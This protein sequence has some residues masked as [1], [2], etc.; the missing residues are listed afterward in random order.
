M[1]NLNWRA[2][3][4]VLL[5]LFGSIALLQALK[6][7]TLKGDLW[8]W[9]FAAIFLVAGVIFL[10]TFVQDSKNNWWAAIPGCTLAGLGAMIALQN[11]PGFISQIAVMIFLGAIGL[12]FILILLVQRSFW[13]ALIPGGVMLSVALLVG[14]SFLPGFN[15][16]W[17]M[18]L[19]FAATFAAVALYTRRPGEGFFHWAWIPALVFVVLGGLMSLES[20]T[21]M[22]Y[23]LP[24]GLLLL[25][26]FFVWR[27]LKA[28]QSS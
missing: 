24:A 23:I 1:K 7:V 12:S 2:L 6:V 15:S 14:L 3:V 25:G 27:S 28:G 17:L 20:F 11:I 16:P 26:G 19:G 13:W 10:N 8:S 18:F 4:G 21:L 22:R 9:A 5:I